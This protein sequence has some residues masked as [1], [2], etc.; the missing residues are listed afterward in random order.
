MHKN[1]CGISYTQTE[2]VLGTRANNRSEKRTRLNLNLDHRRP[3]LGAA[4]EDPAARRSVR[5]SR[6]LKRRQSRSP[7]LAPSRRARLMKS[8][9]SGAAACV[10]SRR[11]PASRTWA[12]IL[13][14]A[15]IHNRVSARDRRRHRAFPT[16]SGK[17]AASA[18][19]SRDLVAGERTAAKR[20][21]PCGR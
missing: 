5:G 18:R 4:G 21:K 7:G 2:A 9:M 16:A 13:G 8:S 6:P 12:S 19:Y 17:A 3:G 10:S 14:R 1:C 20:R 11:W 15:R